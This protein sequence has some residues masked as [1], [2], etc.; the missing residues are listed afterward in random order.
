MNLPYCQLF[1]NNCLAA[2]SNRKFLL[3]KIVRA[4]FD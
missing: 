2:Y 1:L 4:G 3:V